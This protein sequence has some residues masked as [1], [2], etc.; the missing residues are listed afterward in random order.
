[1]NSYGINT[2]Q[3]RHKY[4]NDTAITSIIREVSG[5]VLRIFE[6][7]RDFYKNGLSFDF[8]KST[9]SLGKKQLSVEKS[10]KNGFQCI[11]DP[12]EKSD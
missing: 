6:E 7:Y 3:I 5:S 1:M 8:H 4:G 12:E 11:S 2:A 10:F 9:I